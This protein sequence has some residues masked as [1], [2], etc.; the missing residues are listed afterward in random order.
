MSKPVTNQ[1][2]RTM[3]DQE[4]HDDKAA[5]DFERRLLQ[6]AYDPRLGDPDRVAASPYR[7]RG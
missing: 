7:P 3:I 5:D 4:K 2:V 6:H 1:M